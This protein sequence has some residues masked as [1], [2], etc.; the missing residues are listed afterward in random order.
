[1]AH[2]PT[3]GTPASSFG[4]PVRREFG[5]SPSEVRA[6]GK[7]ARPSQSTTDL[8]AVPPVDRLGALLHRLQAER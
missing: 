2:A 6:A 3:H 7:S 8:A 1:M 4:D 5:Y